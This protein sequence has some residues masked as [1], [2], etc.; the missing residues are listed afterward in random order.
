M[1]SCFFFFVKIDFQTIFNYEYVGG[2]YMCVGT[3]FLKL[4]LQAA[5]SHGS[6][7]LNLGFL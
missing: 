7:E 6:W 5:V 2:A 4:N 1:T 3:G